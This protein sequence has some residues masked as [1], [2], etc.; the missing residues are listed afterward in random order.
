MLNHEQTKQLKKNL[1]RDT[2]DTK[3]TS[4]ALVSKSIPS[5]TKSSVTITELDTSDSECLSKDDSA[6]FVESFALLTNT[7][8]RFA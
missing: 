3:S 2:K 8:R 6:D 1:V 5:A 4:V 7:F